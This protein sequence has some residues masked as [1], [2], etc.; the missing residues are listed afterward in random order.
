VLRAGGHLHGATVTGIERQTI[1]DG[2]GF[3]GELT[4]LTLTYDRAEAGA[5]AT[6][7]SKLPTAFAPARGLANMFH[8][9]EREGRFYEHVA[10]QVDLRL[11]KCYG[12]IV[13]VASDRYLL[14][15]EDIRGA[16]PGDQLAGCQVAHAETVIEHIAGFHAHWW[17]NPALEGFAAWMPTMSDPMYDYLQPLWQASWQPFLDFQTPEFPREAMQ[18][19]ADQAIAVMPTTRARLD[20]MPQSIAH[21][22]FR[23]DNM[24]FGEAGGETPFAL[25]DWQLTLRGPAL[26]DIGYFLS[27]SLDVELRRAHEERLVREYHRRLV[28]AGVKDYSFEQCWED[29]R[30][31]VA[32]M[33]VIPVTGAANLDSTNPRSVPLLR[34][35]AERGAAAIIDLKAGETLSA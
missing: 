3:L 19:F 4:R 25:I 26:I 15:L 34:A 5:P 18:T 16:T 31:A 20:A 10:P 29:Y 22:D 17:Q 24:F 2:V 7:V 23:L 8:F 32:V 30:F 28:D 6:L 14:L 12:N 9:Y 27:Q 13:D 35:L 21:T 33:F 11:P 1:G